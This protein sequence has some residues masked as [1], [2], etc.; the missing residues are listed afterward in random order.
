MGSN[1]EEKFG[2]KILMNA[3]KGL[4][5]PHLEDMTLWLA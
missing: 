2:P 4:A 3:S 5:M 1:E